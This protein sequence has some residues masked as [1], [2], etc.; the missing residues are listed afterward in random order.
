MRE[1]RAGVVRD[2]FDQ[3]RAG[4]TFATIAAYLGASQPQLVSCRSCLPC[5]HSEATRAFQKDRRHRA[6]LT[7]MLA[8][9]RTG[10]IKQALVQYAQAALEEYRPRGFADSVAVLDACFAALAHR[11]NPTS[12]PR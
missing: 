5:P 8:E 4:S 6:Y 7:R 1:C 10:S 2:V 12:A 3:D 11:V 9:S